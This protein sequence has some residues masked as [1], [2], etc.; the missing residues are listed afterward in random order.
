MTSP[1]DAP[2]RNVW[3][4]PAAGRLIP[5]LLAVSVLAVAARMATGALPPYISE[6][7]VGVLA[8]LA[9]AN[10]GHVHH[11]L[12]AG[13]RFAV[14]T[15][16]RAGIVLLGAKLSLDQVVTTGA[17]SL[18]IILLGLVLVA[19][20]IMLLGRVMS[21]PPRLA[22][23]IGVGTAI[24]GNSA[25]VA[26]APIIEAEESD[27]SFAVATITLFGTAAVIIYPLIGL[28]FG[29]SDALYGQW[30]GMAVNDTS[31]VTAAAFAYSDD[32][33]NTATIVKLTRNAL[34]GP[35]LVAVGVV[36]P[37]LV[38]GPGDS[39]RPEMRKV[40]R[41]VPLFVFGFIA[42]AAMNSLGAVPQ[43]L[44]SAAYDAAKFMILMALVGLGL[45]TSVR[46]LRSVGLAPLWVGLTASVALSAVALT[47]SS[48]TLD[49]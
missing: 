23:L 32:A 37:L 41:S 44:G 8:G 5:G 2:G 15:L 27:V 36:Y 4:T 39:G 26:T 34:I 47:L 30:V 7:S 24:C 40:I 43:A 46:R 9:L 20:V 16:L 3:P 18:L 13:I 1:A 33:G 49:P 28:I 38:A 21:V 45:Q 11:V 19:T 31:Q 35:V 25:I 42:L 10:L 29:M 22:L 17:G 12:T 48:I 6:V 14:S